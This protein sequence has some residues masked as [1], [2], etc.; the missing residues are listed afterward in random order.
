MYHGMNP[1]NGDGSLEQQQQQPQSPQRLLA[2]IL[3]F[4]LA[5]FFGPA[6]LTGGEWPRG[7]REG[8]GWQG[9][10]TWQAGQPWPLQSP[11]SPNPPDFWGT[12]EPEEPLCPSPR[13]PFFVQNPWSSQKIPLWSLHR[14][15]HPHSVWSFPLATQPGFSE[16][17]TI[18]LG[19]LF[20]L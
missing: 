5:L 9:G 4:Q 17:K 15:T 14:F 2:V 3:W 11:P 8:L 20:S 12:G 19:P 6:Q 16:G 18:S 1:S 7:G 10:G 13:P